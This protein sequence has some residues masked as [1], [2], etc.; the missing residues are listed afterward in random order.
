MGSLVRLLMTIAPFLS[1]LMP[2]TMILSRDDLFFGKSLFHVRIPLNGLYMILH[3]T[4]GAG[5]QL[6]RSV[7]MGV[8]YQGQLGSDAKDH[9]VR[10]NVGIE[11]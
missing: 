7:N 8:S 5:Q 11:F 3:L 4:L 1:V 6:S 10:A 2:R 9:G